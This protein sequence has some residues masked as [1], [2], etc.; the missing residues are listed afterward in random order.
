MSRGRTLLLVAF[1]RDAEREGYDIL[2]LSGS[3]HGAIEAWIEI[4]QPGRFAPVDL[5]HCGGRV[6]AVRAPPVY[7]MR[8]WVA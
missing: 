4:H 2:V 7:L 5:T 8:A 3:R 6:V 1:L